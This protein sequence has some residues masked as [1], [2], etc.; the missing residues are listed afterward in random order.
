MLNSLDWNIKTVYPDGRK[1]NI[2]WHEDVYLSFTMFGRSRSRG[3]CIN[4]N[5]HSQHV[6]AY[7]FT[8]PFKYLSNNGRECFFIKVSD[9]LIINLH[10]II[11]NV[12][13][14][15]SPTYTGLLITEAHCY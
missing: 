8:I 13:K 15:T 9:V 6:A 4:R 3:M 7:V 5:K 2:M 14:F 11:N 12:L 10:P 1:D